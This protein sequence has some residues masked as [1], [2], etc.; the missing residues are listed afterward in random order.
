MTNKIQEI[1]DRW[2]KMP[3]MN[4]VIYDLGA[5]KKTLKD[6]LIDELEPQCEQPVIYM[7]PGVNVAEIHYSYISPSK[8]INQKLDEN[9][10]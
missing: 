5:K 6:K 2:L 10:E 7:S 1:F 3:N 4:G 8:V 9:N